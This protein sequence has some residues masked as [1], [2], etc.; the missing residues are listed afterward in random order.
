MFF[1]DKETG[2]TVES[3]QAACPVTNDFVGISYK[4]SQPNQCY[5]LYNYGSLPPAPE[6]FMAVPEYDTGTGP[7]A[8]GDGSTGWSCHKYHP[9]R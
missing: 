3:C 4:V 9:E 8:S 1:R 2:Y 7:I 5:C 6:G